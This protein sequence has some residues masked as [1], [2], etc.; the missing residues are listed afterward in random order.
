MTLMLLAA[1]SGCSEQELTHRGLQ[2]ITV[3]GI[4]VDI[5]EG[6]AALDDTLGERYAVMDDWLSI[7]FE[8]RGDTYLVLTEI[9]DESSFTVERYYDVK[10]DSG[11]SA[12]VVVY[13]N[14]PADLSF[15]DYKE[16]YDGLWAAEPYGDMPFGENF[17]EC[18][19]AQADGVILD[20]NE[21]ISAAEKAQTTIYNYFL[22]QIESND[23]QQ[24]VLMINFFDGEVC[25]YC[26]HEVF[27][28][29]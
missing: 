24:L 11:E 17:D 28:A 16:A 20:P 4:T 7:P 19:I 3:D 25:F 2:H 1:V 9:V 14:M 22:T 26:S 29:K 8:E 10:V 27:N 21:Y 5:T 12:G 18:I 23:I 15:S 6:A 13:R